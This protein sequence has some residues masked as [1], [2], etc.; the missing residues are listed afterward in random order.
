VPYKWGGSTKQATDCSGFVMAVHQEVGIPF[1]T[2]PDSLRGCST[3]QPRPRN[4]TAVW[5]CLVYPGHCAIYIGDGKTAET[6]RQGRHYATV[7][8]P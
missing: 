1:R 2:A 3:G 5:R 6:V 8:V 4:E 7:L